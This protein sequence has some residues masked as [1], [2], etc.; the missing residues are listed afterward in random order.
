MAQSKFKTPQER[1]VELQRE[2]NYIV[3]DDEHTQ[4]LSLFFVDEIVELLV[5][6]PYIASNDYNVQY[7]TEV[8]SIIRQNE[9]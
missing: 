6:M 3:C 1:A 8:Q 5:S 7:W 2:I 9:I 4:K